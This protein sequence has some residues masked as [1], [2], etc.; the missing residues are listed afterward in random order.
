MN[1][2]DA[3]GVG[4]AP[5]HVPALM[6]AL[7]LPVLVF[8]VRR[9]R[10]P[11]EAQPA[12]PVRATETRETTG[13]GAG[14][15]GP[16]RGWV[17][18]LLGVAAAVHLALPL[19]H[20]DGPLLAVAFLGSGAAYAWLAIRAWEGR[21]WRLLSALLIVATLIAYLAV[22]GTGREEPDQV[23]IAT[24]LVELAALGFCLVPGGRTATA[25]PTGER[26]QGRGLGQGL[27]LG[28]GQ[29][30]VR[31]ARARMGRVAGSASFVAITFVVGAVVWVG[32]FAAHAASD[33]D[34]S[35]ADSVVDG[36]GHSGDHAHEHDHAARAQAGVIMRPV[37][38]QHPSVGQQLAADRLA[39][40]T[41]EATRRYADL[42]A[43]IAAGYA[44]PKP[45]TGMDV[46]LE[47]KAFRSDGRVLDPQRPETLVYAIE[48]G[49]ATLLG[50]VFVMERA[51]VAAPEP[52]G[53]ITRWHA[54]NVCV[55]ALPPGFGIV[56]PF[57]GC[58]A[59]S[60]NLTTPE[61]M[62][63]WVVANPGGWFAEGLDRAWVRGYH[64][65]HG[66]AY[67]SR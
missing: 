15:A 29:G 52:G 17:A 1:L 61:M 16:V 3:F 23:G 31:L 13:V 53:P 26:G 48:G 47:N 50:V 30:T 4:I 56:S 43:A 49:R 67:A 62:H 27:G 6:A 14:S 59:L 40:A 8:I 35:T 37:V 55:T 7:L 39:A 5:Q 66:T 2:I 64:A 12:V 63:V 24:A 36:V 28:R 18:W 38:D 20:Y 9:I 54:H 10:R 44:L 11:I 58:P 41:R 45:G 60:V 32:S 21:S 65:A 57:G 22:A 33:T 46:H 42:D 34:V 25:R 51:G 19:G